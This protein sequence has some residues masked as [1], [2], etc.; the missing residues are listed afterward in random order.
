MRL[1][2]ACADEDEIRRGITALARV[3]EARKSIEPGVGQTAGMHL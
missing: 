1:T 2:V 3:V